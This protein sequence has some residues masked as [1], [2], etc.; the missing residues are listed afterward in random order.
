MLVRTSKV[1]SLLSQPSTSPSD[2]ESLPK[3]SIGGQLSYLESSIEL[4]SQGAILT[5][6]DQ[7]HKEEG[8]IPRYF[9]NLYA[10]CGRQR[11]FS[12]RLLTSSYLKLVS[13]I[14]DISGEVETLVLGRPINFAQVYP[15]I[16]RSSFPKLEHFQYLKG[17]GVHS[18][19]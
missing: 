8:N 4:P 13:I 11:L 5:K 3:Q 15:S 17:I 2:R 19:L 9:S 12:R 7:S 14:E 6:T 18:I 1:H 16:Y 10:Y